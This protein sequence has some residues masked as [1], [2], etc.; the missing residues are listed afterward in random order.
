MREAHRPEGNRPR[1][2]RQVLP[3][4]RGPMAAEEEDPGGPALLRAPVQAD[5]QVSG[6][7]RPRQESG[8]DALGAPGRI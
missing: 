4:R 6:L 7:R 5:P 1:H 8:G 3:P 2:V